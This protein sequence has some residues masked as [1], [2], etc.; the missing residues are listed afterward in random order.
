MWI[1][2]ETVEELKQQVEELNRTLKELEKRSVLLD[3]QRTGR[4]IEFMFV[5]GTKVH[6]I[7]T[8]SLI[9][10]D[11]KRWKDVLLR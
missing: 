8:M 4:K 7:E 9:S 5:R 2:R 1:R 6:T 3:I 11:I 10:D